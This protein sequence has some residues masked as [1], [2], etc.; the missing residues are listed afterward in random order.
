MYR[1]RT[2][3]RHPRHCNATGAH[4][5]MDRREN[6]L[7]RWLGHRLLDEIAYVLICRL[8]RDRGARTDH[9]FSFLCE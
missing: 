2:A 7:Q 5:V 4:F 6:L 3:A 1:L 9:F 8:P